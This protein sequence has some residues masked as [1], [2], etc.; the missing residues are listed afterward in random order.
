MQERDKNEHY[1][2]QTG[3]KLRGQANKF[4]GAFGFKPT[5]LIPEMVY[6]QQQALDRRRAMR[7]I[8]D[9]GRS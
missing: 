4:R 9:S 3:H 5:T 6:L 2:D 7:R 8:T 1:A